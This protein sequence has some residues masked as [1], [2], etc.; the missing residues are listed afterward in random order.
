M[1]CHDKNVVPRIYFI[2]SGTEN[3]SNGHTSSSGQLPL[4]NDSSPLISD[5]STLGSE[6]IPLRSDETPCRNDEPSSGNDEPS[7]KSDQSHLKSER[8]LSSGNDQSTLKNDQT[9]FGSEQLPLMN[10]QLS[11]TNDQSLLLESEPLEGS[12]EVQETRDPIEIGSSGVSVEMVGITKSVNPVVQQAEVNSN[13]NP[14]AEYEWMGQEEEFD[15]EV[16]AELEEEEFIE[17]CFEEMLAEEEADCFYPPIDLP[18]PDIEKVQ[19]VASEQVMEHV[20]HDEPEVP[21]ETHECEETSDFILG[22]SPQR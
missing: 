2:M 21:E 14:F 16:L 19:E 8:S 13:S 3:W 6:H 15:K 18:L 9:S 5:Q 22:S 17:I 11:V 10:D 1:A 4:S 7:I 20:G 12:M